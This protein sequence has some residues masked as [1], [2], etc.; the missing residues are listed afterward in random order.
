MKY[1]IVKI[2]FTNSIIKTYKTE[3]PVFTKKSFML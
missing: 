1:Y 2:T 3:Y